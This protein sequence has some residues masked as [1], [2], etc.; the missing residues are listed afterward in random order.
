M[1]RLFWPGVKMKGSIVIATKN[2]LY[3]SRLTLGHMNE[4]GV[5]SSEME[6][7]PFSGKETDSSG[8]DMNFKS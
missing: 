5:F 4:F 6:P 2:Y 7:E 8:K 3:S 1:K